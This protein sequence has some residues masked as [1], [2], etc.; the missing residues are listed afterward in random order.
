M[1]P[2][3]NVRTASIGPRK[4]EKVPRS[5]PVPNFNSLKP[6]WRL[7]KLELC[8]PFGWHEMTGEKLQEVVK[9]L[10]AFEALTWGEILVTQKHRNHSILVEKLSP[11]ARRRLSE[12]K[13]DDLDELV[14]LRLSGPNRVFGIREQGILL[15]MWWDPDHGVCPSHL[16]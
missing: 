5:A 16:S 1:P 9:K 3:K 2:P 15:L 10:G 7:A 4:V 13:L 11:S 12:L 8:G 14:S 6:A